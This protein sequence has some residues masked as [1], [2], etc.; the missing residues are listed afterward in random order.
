MGPGAQPGP[1]HC[2]APLP[3]PPWGARTGRRQPLFHPGG[4]LCPLT[5]PPRCSVG[6]GVKGAGPFLSPRI[7][8]SGLKP[9][10]SACKRSRQPLAFRL[11]PGLAWNAGAENSVPPACAFDLCPLLWLRQEPP[12]SLDPH[13][14]VPRRSPLPWGWEEKASCSPVLRGPWRSEHFL[15]QLRVWVKPEG[16]RDSRPSLL[17]RQEAKH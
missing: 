6:S 12:V 16:L 11:A 8:R 10:T 3:S 13:T 4:P 2:P 15:P 9:L 14:R 1:V 17:T 7:P 5:F